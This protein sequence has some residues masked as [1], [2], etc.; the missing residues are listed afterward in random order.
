MKLRRFNPDGVASFASYR[1]RLTLEPTLPPPV[2]MLEDPALTELMPGDVDVPKRSFN[3]RLEV[4][5][6]LNELFGVAKVDLPER[7]QG[8]WTWL[9][10]FY[11]DEVCPE[12]GNGR[13]NP[14]DE[15]RLIAQVDNFQRF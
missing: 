11:L 5:R 10:L 3:N 4:G 6:F 2:E 7:D 15:A 1:A 12:D 13:R 9:T 14:K 8:L